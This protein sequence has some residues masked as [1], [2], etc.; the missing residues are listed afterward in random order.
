MSEFDKSFFQNC[1]DILQGKAEDGLS[2]A[3]MRFLFSLGYLKVGGRI[4]PDVKSRQLAILDLAARFERLFPLP[5]KNAPGAFF[6]GGLISP[7][8][9]GGSGHSG[10]PVGVSGRGK[11]LK[12]AFESC[13]GEAAEYA[14]SL[15]EENDDRIISSITESGLADDDLM[16]LSGRAVKDE[17]GRFGN[18]W[19]AARSLSSEHQV[20]LPADIVLRKRN[21]SGTDYRAPSSSGLGAGATLQDAVLSGLME[22]IERDAIALWWYGG[23][24][25]RKLL[26][27][28]GLDP[29]F[30]RFVSSVRSRGSRPFWL[31]DLTTDLQIPVVAAL[32]SK[33]DGTSVIAGFSARPDY[34]S[35]LRSAF[36]EMC[37]MELA[38]EISL[39]RRSEKGM[40]GLN[41][42]DRKWVRLHDELSVSNYPELIGIDAVTPKIKDTSLPSIKYSVDQLGLNGLEAYAVDLTRKVIGINVCRVVVPGLQ[43]YGTDIVTQRLNG[44]AKSYRTPIVRNFE[45]VAII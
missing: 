32:S 44:V 33:T 43:P 7:E 24:P 10:E 30:H 9:I 16:L 39:H 42:R 18:D 23:L 31:L 29:E 45:K 4:D 41:E 37:Q 20:Y 38:Q 1:T 21:K 5:M 15:E 2:S 27:G 22:V 17:K 19:I 12:R 25:A 34:G 8:A 36:L 35:A 13:I 26:L 28:N 3:E 14:S 6:W 11:T 40:A